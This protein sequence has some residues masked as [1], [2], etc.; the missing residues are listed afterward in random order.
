MSCFAFGPFRPRSRFWPQNKISHPDP[1]LWKYGKQTWWRIISST[2][3]AWTFPSLE[4]EVVD[5]LVGR[6]WPVSKHI[7]N[8]FVF[9]LV[10]WV[11]RKSLFY[12]FIKQGDHISHNT[13]NQIKDKEDQTDC[14]GQIG[15][16]TSHNTLPVCSR[17]QPQAILLKREGTELLG[18]QGWNNRKGSKSN[19]PKRHR[20]RVMW[21]SSRANDM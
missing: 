17:L 7:N 13:S 3:N 15:L 1:T 9:F 16:F 5:V 11:G 18:R 8:S 21:P 4:T 12:S 20:E 2:H 14:T 19:N 10:E 6:H